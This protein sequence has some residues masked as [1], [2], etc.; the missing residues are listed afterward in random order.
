MFRTSHPGWRSNVNTTGT[1][2]PS[3]PAVIAWINV[4][5]SSSSRSAVPSRITAASRSATSLSAAAIRSGTC[6]SATIAARSTRNT[7]RPASAISVSTTRPR[8]VPSGPASSRRGGRMPSSARRICAISAGFMTT[9]ATVRSSR[10]TR[11]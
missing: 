10:P 7:G 1:G 5:G 8:P 2:S 9:S 11:T 3:S 4:R 6:P